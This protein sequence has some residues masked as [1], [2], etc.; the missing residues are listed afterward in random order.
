[1]VKRSFSASRNIKFVIALFKHSSKRYLENR[2]ATLGNFV[3]ATLEI[4]IFIFFISFIFSF[5]KNLNGWDKNHVLLLVGISQLVTALYNFLFRRSVNRFP[6]LVRNGDLDL[7]LT[8]PINAQLYSSFRYTKPFE[9]LN[10]ATGI[11][12]AAYA[13]HQIGSS[14]GLFNWLL[15]LVGI[16]CGVLVLYSICFSFTMLAFWSP[17]L[18]SASSILEIITTPLT[19]PT[20]IYGQPMSFIITFVIPIGLVVTVPVK[21]FLGTISTYFVLVEVLLTVVFFYACTRLWNYAVRGYTSAS[22]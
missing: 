16:I 6:D 11:I 18:N 15:L 4:A 17:K 10:I 19:L 12:I 3:S 2:W 1:M 22:S 5:T 20:D 9:I 7:L 21:L 8:K 13:L 14:F